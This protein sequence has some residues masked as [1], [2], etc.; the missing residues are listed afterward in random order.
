MKDGVDW[1]QIATA[2]VA[3]RYR[4]GPAVPNATI[5]QIESAKLNP[6][7]S[8]LKKILDGVPMSLLLRFSATTTSPMMTRFLS[9]GA[10]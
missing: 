3:A 8:M 2:G 10:G 1:C 6:T 4:A 9:S 5:S 7:V